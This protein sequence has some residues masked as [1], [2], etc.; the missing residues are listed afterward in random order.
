RGGLQVAR[1]GSRR[2]AGAL[3]PGE[4]VS[5]LGLLGTEVLDVA[6]VRRHLERRARHH[7]HAVALEPTDL[8]RVVGEE[9]HALHA[10]VA[11]DLCPDAVVA[12]ILPEAELEVR[13]HRVAALVLEGVG[14]DLVGEPDAPALLAEVDEDAAA[15]HRDRLER[16][17]ALVAAVAAPRAEDL[18]GPA[19][20]GPA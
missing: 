4:E 16:L 6:R 20:A 9:A 8:L 1:H 5:E 7:V 2:S 3:E 14:A 18:A 19:P 11:Q 12:Q 15:R 13:L 10:Q 17:A